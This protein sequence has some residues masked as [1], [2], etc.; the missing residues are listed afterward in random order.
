[1][2]GEGDPIKRSGRI[3]NRS[4]ELES[5]VNLANNERGIT[6]ESL[7]N[8]EIG[9]QRER[10]SHRQSQSLLFVKYPTKAD[11]L[12]VIDIATLHQSVGHFGYSKVAAFAAAAGYRII[13]S[14]GTVEGAK[15]ECSLCEQCMIAKS[16]VL[17][18]FKT[19]HIRRADR[20]G[21]ILHL[22]TQGAWRV[23]SRSGKRYK[24]SVTDDF[25][26]YTLDFYLAHKNE[27]IA[28]LRKAIR[29]FE[30]QS[31]NRVKE[32]RCDQEFTS[33]GEVRE[34]YPGIIW[35][36]SA[37]GD[38]DGNPVAERMNQTTGGP[39]RAMRIHA[40]FPPN[41]WDEMEHT[42]STMWNIIPAT[43]GPRQGMSPY[44]QLFGRKPPIHQLKPIGS[45]GVMHIGKKDGKGAM[46][47]KLVTLVG[48]DIH[49]ELYRVWDGQR[50]ISGVRNARFNTRKIGPLS[51]T[52]PEIA[53]SDESEGETE[54]EKIA[55]SPFTSPVEAEQDDG[56][57][58]QQPQST[59]PEYE[60][61][62]RPDS[63]TQQEEQEPEER[64]DHLDQITA[65]QTLQEEQIKQVSLGPTPSSDFSA[66]DASHTGP[67][68]YVEGQP[69]PKGVTWE[70][71]DGISSSNIITG[72]RERKQT[73]ILTTSTHHV[74]LMNSTNDMDECVSHD[75]ASEWLFYIHLPTDLV[76]EGMSIK[77]LQKGIDTEL[78][79]LRE[80]NTYEWASAGELK[81]AGVKPVGLLWVHKVKTDDKG[82]KFVKSRLSLRGDQLQPGIS[83]N[84]EQL[85]VPCANHRSVLLLFKLSVTWGNKLYGV[86]FKNAYL[87]A[88][89]KD[90]VYAR[91]P[92]G[93][94]VKGREGMFLK[95]TKALYGAPQAGKRWYDLFAQLLNKLNY[96]TM[97]ADPCMFK[98]KGVPI[99]EAIVG[100]FHVDDLI[101]IAP[102]ERAY[103]R[104]C[105]SLELSFPIKR[106]GLARE[107]KGMEIEQRDNELIVHQKTYTRKVLKFFGYHEAK[108]SATPGSKVD[109]APMHKSAQLRQYAIPQIV[110]SLLYLAKMTRP[111]IDE[112]VN[113]AS[114][115]QTV[116][117]GV[118][119][120]RL[121]K[122]LR[123]IRNLRGLKFTAGTLKDKKEEISVYPDAAHKA[124]L[125]TGKSRT[126][127]VVLIGD[128]PVAWLS[129]RQTKV[130]L[131]SN[132]A[133][134]IAANE[135]LREMMAV[136]N[137]LLELG[138]AQ[139]SPVDVYEDNA[140]TILAA[141]RG[142]SGPR[143][144]HLLVEEHYLHELESLGIVKFRKVNTQD[145]LGDA[146]TKY[147]PKDQMEYLLDKFT[148][149][150]D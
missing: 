16:K 110:G 78:K 148:V 31:G 47:G 85:Y 46:P 87:N 54:T 66:P 70:Q 86:D 62:R 115:L 61:A 8:R 137:I 25:S 96:E 81:R 116:D 125:K 135:A 32:I 55:G 10:G 69:P 77:D 21:E 142:L 145:Q 90:P 19:N 30:T 44:E 97:K 20:P 133:E 14:K 98:Q 109:P 127:Y 71:S 76:E 130:A 108:P 4:I 126:G 9:S 72:K 79:A 91:P 93:L 45:R 95:I 122:C 74:T 140:Q 75:E 11:R 39:A 103:N 128:C 94:D 100:V 146:L 105:D 117:A 82:V 6:S 119:Y 106:L 92:T 22:D 50:V 17:P 84:P 88:L 27:F 139:Q 144:K 48:Y 59:I 83:Y 124:C 89:M 136:R 29:F 111:D 51:N 26:V 101:F 57:E 5:S 147:L 104:F 43:S 134:I 34:E 37:T 64:I 73:N 24:F 121:G 7:S 23:I 123:Y 63:P 1:V 150:I 42:A 114:V 33:P 120:A 60:L 118:A 68:R 28:C 67:T 143:T 38:K 41:F 18:R 36:D 112:A 107:F 129:K 13:S 149:K 40:G 35:R 65:E 49:R 15:E 102:H 53:W 131:S 141:Q 138:L 52:P 58:F 132:D 80:F 12:K 113:A 99:R 56:D 3:K 2:R